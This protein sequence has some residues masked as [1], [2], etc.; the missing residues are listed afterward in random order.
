MWAVLTP[1]VLWFSRR[2]PINSKTWKSALPLH[3]AASLIL[4]VIQVSIEGSI[5]WFRDAGDLSLENALRHYLSQ[6]TQLSILAYWVL[7]SACTSANSSRP[8]VRPLWP[9]SVLVSDSLLTSLLN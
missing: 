7:V 8:I 9:M 1:L 6:H 5:G 2:H 4:T 3:A